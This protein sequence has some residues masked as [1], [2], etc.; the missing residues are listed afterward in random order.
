MGLFSK[1]KHSLEDLP[2]NTLAATGKQ[3]VKGT[4]VDIYVNDKLTNGQFQ[5]IM[6]DMILNL[7]MDLIVRYNL[8]VNVVL[9][10]FVADVK[11]TH[12]DYIQKETK[13]ND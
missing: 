10:N 11:R 12:H 3:T 6:L 9:D 4:E 13:E 5:K 1:K 7:I 8:D 2:K